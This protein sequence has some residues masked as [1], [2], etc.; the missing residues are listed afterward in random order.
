MRRLGF[1][2]GL[3]FCFSAHAQE[4]V[5]TPE[6]MDGAW[7]ALHHSSDGG[8]H[9]DACILKA[10]GPVLQFR[11]TRKA[12]AI[13]VADENASVGQSLPVTLTAGHFTRTFQMTS[14]EAAT[15]S[16]GVEAGVIRSTL[17]AFKKATNLTI[18]ING[19][20]GEP[21][22][23]DGSSRTLDAFLSCMNTQGF[24]DQKKG[25]EQKQTR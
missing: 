6:R 18:R 22:S 14:A 15:L 21:I 1:T 23:L 19:I 16:A 24:G 25:Q 11:A 9:V 5:T 7:V 2:A 12:L 4:A 17:E 3:L 8:E 10:S 13:Q 20:D